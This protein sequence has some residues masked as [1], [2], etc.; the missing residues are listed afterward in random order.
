M[1]TSE[2]WQRYIRGAQIM[3]QEL[4]DRCGRDNEEYGDRKMN[5]EVVWSNNCERNGMGKLRLYQCNCNDDSSVG[6]E[7][8][9][10]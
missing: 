5:A 8:M 7:E 2:K 4:Y 10:E 6:G 1:T 9:S 3:A